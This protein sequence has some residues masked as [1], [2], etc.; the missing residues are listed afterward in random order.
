[1]G[2]Y[3]APSGTPVHLLVHGPL[4]APRMELAVPIGGPEGEKRAIEDGLEVRTYEG[5]DA[6][7][8]ELSGGTLRGTLRRL[9]D[10]LRL[11]ARSDGSPQDGFI[12]YGISRTGDTYLVQARLSLMTD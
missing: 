1:M 4:D 12:A 8:A 6:F 7:A 9:D 3:G 2:T 10:Q 5:G 11:A